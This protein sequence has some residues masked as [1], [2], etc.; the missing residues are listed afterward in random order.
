M[1][2]IL[3][4]LLLFPVFA[5]AGLQEDFLAIKDNGRNLQDVGAI[6]EDMA[7]LQLRRQYPSDKYVVL[8]GISYSDR[9]GVVGE[10][11][12]VVFQKQFGLAVLVG[13]VKCWGDYQSG[14]RKAQDQRKRFLSYARSGRELRFHWLADPRILI[15]KAQF[16]NINEFVT[17]GQKGSRSAGYD[18]EL[19]YTVEE[20]MKLRNDIMLC[21]AERRCPRPLPPPKEGPVRTN[22]F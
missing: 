1:K 2:F 7:Q 16:A 4:L 10:L 5:L 14:L 6:C 19:P 21:Q 22:G 11:D 13:E 18:I 8:T 3:C 17:I 12:V 9:E 15:T 20:L